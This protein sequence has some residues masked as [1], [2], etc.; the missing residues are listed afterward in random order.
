MK[1]LVAS[2]CSFTFENWNWPTYT[3][4]GLGLGE[5][6]VN[7]GMGSQGN[8]IIARKLLFTLNNLLQTE[9]PEDIIVGVMWSGVDR[10]DEY[11]SVGGHHTPPDMSRWQDINGFMENPTS[12]TSHDVRKNWVIMNPHWKDE[13]S[14]TWYKL[15]HSYVGS[16]VKTLESILLVQYF[17]KEKGIRYFM[18]TYMDIFEHFD[19]NDL[20]LSYLYEQIDFT[21]FIPIKGCYEWVK[22]NC[23]TK[24]LPEG[25]GIHPTAYGHE[26]FTKDVIIPFLKGEE[27]KD[28]GRGILI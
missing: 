27:I 23:G 20:D 11:I 21:N 26:R 5:N 8:G 18:T 22:T 14:T 7:V 12:I 2:G 24:G 19:K 28:V 4:Y 10:H 9:K 13:Y 17:C 16:W 1:K 25:D 15:F 6:L 3:A